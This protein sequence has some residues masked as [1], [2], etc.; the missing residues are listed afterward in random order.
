MPDAAQLH[1]RSY[2]QQL[3]LRVLAAREHLPASAQAHEVDR[4][5]GEVEADGGD[6]PQHALGC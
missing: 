2:F 6:F 3:V 1:R 4:R 5:L